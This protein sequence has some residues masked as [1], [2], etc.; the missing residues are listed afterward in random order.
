MQQETKETSNEEH[1][2]EYCQGGGKPLS[3]RL[4][5]VLTFATAQTL[6]AAVPTDGGEWA[7]GAGE[8]E[9]LGAAANISRLVVDGS[10]TLDTGAA[11]TATGAVINTISTDTGIVAD[12]TIASGASFTSRGTLTGDNP[13]NTQGFS[14]GSYGGTGTVTVASG[15]LLTVTGGRLFLGRNNLTGTE[16]RT[17]RSHGILNIFGIVDAQT[18]ECGAWFPQTASAEYGTYVV[19]ELP[20]AAEI[21]IEEGG[22]FEFGQF[23]MQD[24]SLTVVNFRGGTIRAKRE[25]NNFVNPAGALSWN[26]ETGK[27]LVFDTA[28]HHIRISAPTVQPDFFQIQGEGGFVKKGAGYLQICG[29]A[30]ASTFSGPIVV[31]E[32][33]LS[34]GR[35]LAEGQT[36]YV[37]S[38]ARFFP[39]GA[40]DAEKITYEDPS[41]APTQG[42]VF[43]VQTRLYDGLDMPGLA[44]TYRTDAL[45]GPIW[46]WGGH[47]HGA[48][49]TPSGIS[50]EH[51]FSLVGQ[52]YSLELYGTGLEDVP[53]TISGTGWFYFDGGHTNKTDNAIT[54]TGAAA[55]QQSGEYVVRGENGEMPVTTISGGSTFKTTGELRVGHN[56]GDGALVV[57]NGVTVNAS[58]HIRLGSNASGMRTTTKGRLVIENATVTTPGCVYI[59]SNGLT[60]GSDR[61][62]L[63][64]ELVLGPG[65]TL[66]VGERLQRND[67]PRSR[68]V[69][70][71]G[72]V[73]ASSSQNQFFYTAQNGVLEIVANGG[74]DIRVNMGA[75]SLG[76]IDSHTHVSGTG[77]LD[78]A[79]TGSSSKFTLGSKTA[80]DFELSYSGATKLTDC[81]M[82]L[83]VPLPAGSTVSGTGATLLLSDVTT[84]NNIVGD[85]SIKGVGSLVV[86]ADGADFAFS[87]RIEGV[88]LVKAGAGTMTLDKPFDGNLVVKGGTVVVRGAA[89]KSYRFKVEAMKGPKQNCMQFSELKF[90]NGGIDVTRPYKNVEYS[91]IV[92]DGK[93]TFSSSE[94]PE[95]VF[96]GNVSTKWCDGRGDYTRPAS[97]KEQL[98]VRINYDSPKAITGYSWYTANDYD[99]R[100]PAAWRLQGSNDGGVTWTDIDVRTGFSATGTR[101]ALAFQSD[102]PGPCGVF[103]PTSRIVVEPGATLRISGGAVPASA[104]EN[105]GGTV[106]LADGA[107]LSTVGGVLDGGM[108]GDGSL[109]IYGGNVTLSGAQTYTGDTHV[110]GG[111]LNVGAASNPLPRAFDGKYFRLTVKRSNGGLTDSSSYNATDYTMQASEFQLYS[112]AGANLC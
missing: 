92:A 100:D 104:I 75:H 97:D 87:N 80:T 59:S 15:G 17:K 19:D 82:C 16:D 63:L 41:E 28:G 6:C 53:L 44:P 61:E 62:T 5:A 85:V 73:N 43:A 60:D 48:I 36:V 12:M 84:T 64:N 79:G 49:T 31:E 37:K 66:N 90:L 21:N 35:P 71:G 93:S 26:I 76:M 10:L 83:N 110:L 67:D 23:Y 72:I 55:Y 33:D 4:F 24:Q 107:T 18:V 34:I 20:V 40:G 52:G 95:K 112:A 50:L 108:S 101:K 106:E 8:T 39:A 81:T 56:G 1:N 7:I 25:N 111:T 105:N 86:G 51:P 78:L 68:I 42:S 32:G 58:P 45:A 109:A 94:N 88:T 47:V 27:N 99:S 30:S 11:L 46:A 13:A 29:Y 91:T 9:S 54:F 22:V 65:A 57:S 98:W 3:Y 69:F 14:I 96:D 77:G 89:Y 74:N 70:N 2:R 103:S 102:L 38:G